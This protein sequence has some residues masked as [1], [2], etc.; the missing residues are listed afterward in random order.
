MA[1]LY[2]VAKLRDKGRH[3]TM[4]TRCKPRKIASRISKDAALD[5][6]NKYDVLGEGNRR[7]PRDKSR[8]KRVRRGKNGQDK[9]RLWSR[10]ID[11]TREEE[12][13]RIVNAPQDRKGK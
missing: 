6:R 2:E 1:D 10:K 5:E 8:G 3:R 13:R 11:K 12:F 9:K 7:W 4:Q